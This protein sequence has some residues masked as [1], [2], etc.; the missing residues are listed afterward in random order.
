MTPPD[1]RSPHKAGSGSRLGGETSENDSAADAKRRSAPYRFSGK[2]LFLR[3][4]CCDKRLLQSDLAVLSVLV[5]HANKFTG[6][7]D[8]Q[9]ISRIVGE[10]G[11]P[12]STALRAVRRLE[13]TNWIVPAKRRGASSSYALTGATLG[14]SPS[15]TTGLTYGTGQGIGTGAI[16]NLRQG[17]TGAT[18][19]TK[20]VPSMGHIQGLQEKQKLQEERTRTRKRAVVVL[21]NWLPPGAWQAWKDHRG[22]KFSEKAQ[23]LAISKLEKLR[24]EGHDPAR[25]IDL[26]IES[27]WVSFYPRDTTK[28]DQRAANGAVTRDT[29]SEA[30]LVAANQ[31]ALARLGG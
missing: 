27:S 29:R 30:E 14:T 26:A 20:P 17:K 18:L 1:E 5:D 23:K 8:Y 13:E 2:L 22:K 21:P 4:A 6:I 3:S 25:L 7:A 28:A 15:D 9:S 19:G 16:R 10:S 11:I 12:K 31:A 24:S